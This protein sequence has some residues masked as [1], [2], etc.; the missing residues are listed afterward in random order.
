MLSTLKTDAAA[1]IKTLTPVCQLSIP[2]NH[3][4]TF[5]ATELLYFA[6]STTQKRRRFEYWIC[7]CTQAESKIYNHQKQTKLMLSYCVLS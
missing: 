2:E 1:F 4:H 5:R 3:N 7:F 6:L